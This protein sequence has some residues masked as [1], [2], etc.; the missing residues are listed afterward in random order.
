MVQGQTERNMSQNDHEFGSCNVLT[1]RLMLK[2]WP[3]C[4]SAELNL[5]V[6]ILG[7]VE[8]NS[9]IALPGKGG[10]SRLVPSKTV[11]QPRGI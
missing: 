2:I 7:E 1:V 4:T 10:Y 8:R 11:S 9:F 3:L 5:G 6:S